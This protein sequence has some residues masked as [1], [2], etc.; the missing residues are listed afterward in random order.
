MEIW[1]HESKYWVINNK[2]YDLLP[3]ISKHPGG[4]EWIKYTQGQE[5][6]EQYV[7]HHLN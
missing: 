1:K 5:I 7:V 3:F 2:M 4:S 6:T